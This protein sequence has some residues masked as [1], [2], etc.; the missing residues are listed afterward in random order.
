MNWWLVR[1]HRAGLALLGQPR[2]SYRRVEQATI[3]DRRLVRR[4][5]SSTA[6]TKKTSTVAYSPLSF[7]MCAMRPVGETDKKSG[8]GTWNFSPP[9]T[10]TSNGTNGV[11]CQNCLSSVAVI[12]VKI[13]ER[14]IGVNR[15][16]LRFAP[17]I[18]RAAS[19]LSLIAGFSLC[20]NA[21]L[22]SDAMISPGRV[23]D[24]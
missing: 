20:H 1:A 4:R 17:E 6:L 11:R 8:C 10:I 5:F 22:E 21:P 14:A 7:Q 24:C 13:M 19:S 12:A 15:F 9:G 2:A 18:P 23:R 3:Y 16:Y